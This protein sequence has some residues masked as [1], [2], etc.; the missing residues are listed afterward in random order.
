ML[1][2]CRW[3]KT[4]SRFLAETTAVN[5]AC[6][7]TIEMNTILTEIEDLK[8]DLISVIGLKIRFSWLKIGLKSI[9]GLKISHS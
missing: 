1:L 7:E 2:I 5:E 6:V 4:R 3:L 8:L 9:I